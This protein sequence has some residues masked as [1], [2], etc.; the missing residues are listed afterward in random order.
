M[1]PNCR[2]KSD[3]PVEHSVPAYWCQKSNRTC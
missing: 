2:Q 1:S 3:K